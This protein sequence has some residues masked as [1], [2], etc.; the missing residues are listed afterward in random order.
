MLKLFFKFRHKVPGFKKIDLIRVS[1]IICTYN[2]IQIWEKNSRCFLEV[3]LPSLLPATADLVLH[4]EKE[5][6]DW[7]GSIEKKKTNFVPSLIPFF[8]SNSSLLCFDF[9]FYSNLHRDALLIARS[10]PPTVNFIPP[11]TP[12]LFYF[13]KKFRFSRFYF[14]NSVISKLDIYRVFHENRYSVQT[15]P[16]SR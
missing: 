5:W 7:F 3:F 12:C 14:Y 11:S 2:K 16:P 6:K 8:T 9:D 10:S 1:R 13:H 15:S 4:E